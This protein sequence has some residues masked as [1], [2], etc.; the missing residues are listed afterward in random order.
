MFKQPTAL[1]DL[2]L[3][4]VDISNEGE[5]VFF[6]V[7]TMKGGAKHLSEERRL[8][9]GCSGIQ[10]R[11]E[12]GS[13]WNHSVEVSDKNLRWVFAN[14]TSPMSYCTHTKNLI[15]EAGLNGNPSAGVVKFADS[16]SSLA[17]NQVDVV[18]SKPGTI[19]FKVRALFGSSF[20]DSPRVFIVA[21]CGCPNLI[22]SKSKPIG[23]ESPYLRTKAGH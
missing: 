23:V 3:E 11:F 1:D 17:C 21:K 4:P 18:I 7:F 2:Y 13:E 9:L 16:C 15:V 5:F 12:A 22:I 6:E 10:V 8:V 14:P 19:S 20:Y